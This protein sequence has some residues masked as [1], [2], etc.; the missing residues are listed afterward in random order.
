MGLVNLFLF[1][2]AITIFPIWIF[3]IWIL[4]VLMP[5]PNYFI[6]KG[7]LGRNRL[8]MGIQLAVLLLLI[9]IGI[10]VTWSLALYGVLLNK[11]VILTHFWF[12]L[13]IIG[14]YIGIILVDIYMYLLPGSL[15]FFI[16]GPVTIAMTLLYTAFLAIYWLKLGK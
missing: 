5:I 3:G 16:V 11:Y 1:L 15:A 13:S 2:I 6:W 4:L 12:L 9:V 7:I 8:A 14:I 10:V